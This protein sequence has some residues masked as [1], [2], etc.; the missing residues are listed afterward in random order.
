M[1]KERNP[2]KSRN[3]ILAAAEKE[4]AEKGFYGA[5]VDEIAAAAEINKRMLYAYFGDKEEL[6]KQVLRHSYR[7][8]EEAEEQLVA[9]KLSGEE[10][11]T[12]I[13]NAYFAFLT[14]NPAFVNLLMWEN[15]NKGRYLKE[16][17]AT[18]IER[19]TIGYFIKAIDEGKEK[20]V[21]RKNIDSFQTVLSLITT[22]FSN[23][24]NQY[25]LSRLFH[26]DLTDRENI[27]MRRK[28]TVQILKT[29]I[30]EVYTDA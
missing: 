15:L 9:R 24:S 30:C 28:H 20:G 4:F 5:R 8:M 21:F 14:E 26:T 1:R 3:M 25:T 16:I 23:F 11:I 6:Y 13:V 18:A 19:K 7:K 17:E 2:E 29:Y 12:G 10:L 22:C 27:E